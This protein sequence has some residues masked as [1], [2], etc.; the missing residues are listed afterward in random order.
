MTP[1]VV[2]AGTYTGRI[3]GLAP[4]VNTLSV[5]Y[6]KALFK[7]VGI[8]KIPKTW[9]EPVYNAVQL[10]LALF[11]KRNFPLSGFLRSLLLPPLIAS[12]AV[13][14]WLPDQESGALDQFPGLVGIPAVP[15]L[16]DPALALSRPPCSPS[17]RRGATSSSPSS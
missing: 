12:S 2:K 13:W 7:A 4:S 8:T 17:C 16:V 15:W 3:H 11:F 10:A 9:D 14:K 1:G 6:N 5:F